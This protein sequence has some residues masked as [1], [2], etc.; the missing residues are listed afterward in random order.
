MNAEQSLVYSVIS[1][2][3]HY[4]DWSGDGISKITIR[5]TDGRRTE[6]DY[7]AGAFG[8]TFDFALV[9]HVESESV[10]RFEL[11]ESAMVRRM[12]G[13]YALTA[14][15]GGKVDVDFELVAEI[16]RVPMFIQRSIANL[17]LAIAVGELGKY[18]VTEKCKKNLQ[19]YGLLDEA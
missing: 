16:N 8:Y 7:K 4:K 9:F 5:N 11:L 15:E 13:A 14:V 18:V 10:V 17:V 19:S 2:F 1:D 3:S 6:V 12:E